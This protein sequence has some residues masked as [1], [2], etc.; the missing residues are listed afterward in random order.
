MNV[1]VQLLI[2][3]KGPFTTGD[4]YLFIHS[5]LRGEGSP[6]PR[7]E[8]ARGVQARVLRGRGESRPAY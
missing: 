7:T 2:Y 3:S 8:G 4:I 6:S 1:L 5:V